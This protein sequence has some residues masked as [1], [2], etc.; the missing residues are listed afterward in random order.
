MIAQFLKHNF[1]SYVEGNRPRSGYY[2]PIIMIKYPLLGEIAC[3]EPIF[4][5]EDRK[6]F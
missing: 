3:G 2:F 6:S 5:D 1:V 4:A